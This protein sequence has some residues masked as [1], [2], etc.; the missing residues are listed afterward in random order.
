MLAAGAALA[1]APALA[2]GRSVDPLLAMP[3]RQLAGL[4]AARKVG[5][6]EVMRAALAAIAAHNPAH[7]AIV[8]L[9]D[10]DALIAEARAFDARPT[11]G[12]LAGLPWAAKEL[13]PVVGFRATQ[14]SL[15]FKDVMARADSIMVQ[16]LR[17][18]GVIMIGKTNAPEFG[19]GSH[20]INRVFGA[21][22]NAWNLGR[23]AGGSTGGG[24]VAVA[25]R[26]L[27]MVDGSDFGG[28][29]R[30]P[31]AWNHVFGL[32][33][34]I[35]TVPQEGWISG[36]GV[37]G[38]MARTVGDLALLLSVQAGQHPDAYLS[39]PVDTAALRGD[40]ASNPKGLRIGWLGDWGGQVPHDP[41]VLALCQDALA[42]FR[43]MGC[44]VEDAA[45]GIAVEP[46]WQAT[47]TLRSWS[48]G[49]QVQPLAENPATRDLIGPQA[50]WE[51]E[52]GRGITGLQISAAAQ[53]RSGFTRAVEQLF[54]R[55][56][57]LVAPAVQIFPFPV[58]QLWPTR[59]NGQDMRT[60]HE[61]QLG[62][63]LITMTGLPS[64]A[65]PAGFG[66]DGLPAGIQIIGRRGGELA[67]LKLA[68]AYEQAVQPLLAK[69]PPELA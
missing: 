48:Y 49:P 36:M 44:V 23:S 54:G 14:G 59:I 16:R 67:L 68:H 63:F 19:L 58:E 24:A 28:S 50:R 60:Y 25:L 5:A 4:I 18:A 20:T 35:G 38:P 2:A 53:V 55:F 21:T 9:R 43:T 32:R 69:R 3:A 11:P 57:V 22:R 15:A 66:P 64:L 51:A 1:A 26:L 61:W 34:S 33:P 27:P 40:L 62:N 17:A 8:Q 10:G 41:G 65:A 39:Q 37:T 30:N 45:P 52:N 31:A 56:D 46:V 13:Q 12:L 7:N 29:L 42:A 6:E 47:Q